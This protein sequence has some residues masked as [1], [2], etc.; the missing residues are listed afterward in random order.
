MTMTLV[1]TV[2]VGSGG[3][4]SIEFTNIA[5]T[6]KDLLILL[7]SRAENLNG[8]ITLNADTSSIYTRKDFYANGSSVTSSQ[9]IN[10]SSFLVLGLHEPKDFNGT[11]NTV[12]MFSNA[13][14]YLPNYSGSVNKF[15]SIDT[16][17]ES[18]QTESYQTMLA[19]IYASTTAI[20]SLKI[21]S[22]S[23]NI[24]QYSTASLYI[25]S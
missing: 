12:S 19:G 17:I 24:L 8:K 25:I 5:Q 1:S 23:G 6:G 2:T 9:A 14:I 22:N 4:T 20:S 13:R 11:N 16:L 15:L 21:E 10:S 18:P 7:S 3:A